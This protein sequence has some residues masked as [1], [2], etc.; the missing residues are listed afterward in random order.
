[1]KYF[2]LFAILAFSLARAAPTS[3]VW[4]LFKA[5]HDKTYETEAEDLLRKEI[6]LNNVQNIEEHNQRF[7]AGEESFKQGINH[8]ADWTASE[9]RTFQLGF[10]STKGRQSRASGVFVADS[11]TDV[12]AE[13]DWRKKGA[14]TGVKNQGDCG[15][16]W[17]FSATGS[18]E[19]AHAINTGELV[20][21]S[22]EQLVECSWSQ[23]NYG[24]DGGDMNPAF[25]YL[26]DAGGQESE[27]DYPYTSGGGHSSHNC[28]FS[29]SKIA[30]TIS[31]YIDVKHGDE[32]AL[33]QAVATTGPIAVAIDASHNSFMN[34]KDG[35]YYESRC[36]TKNEDLDHG[37]LVVGYGT[38]DGKDY[39]LVKNSWTASWGEDGYVKMSRNRNNNCGIAT[40]ASYPVVR[41]V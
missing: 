2:I 14:V 20:S 13:I 37:V 34:Y 18:V 7:E 1:M 22:E 25:E 5:V 8:F 10:K 4:E 21:L 11:V 32:E 27:K 36:S 23:G 30:A 24:C 12:P 19:G 41:I 28:K 39:W 29:L 31:D 40:A 17:A 9:Y 6:F 15:S 16:C 35:I 33:K 38:E 3:D 26:I